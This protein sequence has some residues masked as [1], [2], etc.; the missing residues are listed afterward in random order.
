MKNHQAIPLLTMIG[1]A[2]CF[3]LRFLQNRSGFEP[4]TG[5][6]IPGAP[7]AILLPAA[8]ILLAAVVLLLGRRLP[9]EREDSPLD[10]QD[11]F[12]PSSSAAMLVVCGVFLWILSGASGFL[13]AGG[14]ASTI[15]GL[16]IPVERSALLLDRL[17][18]ALTILAA[19]C[20]FPAAA[21]ASS[22]RGK[23][24]EPTGGVPSRTIG[25]LLLLPVIYLVLRLALAYREMSVNASQQA[26]YAELFA[27]MFLILGLYRLSSFAFHC[28]NTLRF[29]LY[30][31]MAVILCITSLA[32]AVSLSDR[33]FFFGSAALM[34]G[35]LLLR[36]SA[37]L[38]VAEHRS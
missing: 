4:D 26:Y 28:G 15:S 3:L 34:L 20:L 8:L 5:L 27:L 29:V 9:N 16:Y 31:A 32:D 7:L 2:G 11:H 12:T 30:A 10:F 23:R 1:G 25:N 37:P 13:S 19:A 14:N 36:L 6:P 33:L 24:V 22:H 21:A 17:L 35:F 38:H 18:H